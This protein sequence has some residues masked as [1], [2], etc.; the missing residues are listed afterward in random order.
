LEESGWM[1]RKAVAA[2]LEEIAQWMEL[3]GE[4]PFKSRS[5]VNGARRIEQVDEDLEVLVRER[6]LREVPGIGE[7]LAE[8]IEELITTGKVAYLDAFRAQFP[9]TLPELFGIPGLGPK[10][11]KQLFEQLGIDSLDALEHACALGSLRV[12]KGF[13]AKMEEKIQGG[14]A[15]ARQHADQYLASAGHRAAL[16]ILAYLDGHPAL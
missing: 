4:N 10:R 1:D 2:V 11:V 12:L 3:T 7:A 14:I 16:E 8:K 5:Y 6:R 13:S 15:F 9:P